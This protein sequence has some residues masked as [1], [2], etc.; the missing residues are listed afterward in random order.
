MSANIENATPALPVLPSREESSELIFS[1]S[2]KELQEMFSGWEAHGQEG[3]DHLGGMAN[4]F[5]IKEALASGDAH[6]SKLIAKDFKALGKR[7]DFLMN[8]EDT[9]A[10]GRKIHPFRAELIGLIAVHIKKWYPFFVTEAL[11]KYVV[12]LHAQGHST[13]NA[14][15][16]LISP[17]CKFPNVFRKIQSSESMLE[18]HMIRWLVPRLAYLKK[19][20]PDFPKKYDE[21]WESAR[22]EYLGEIRSYTLTDTVE[23]VKALS[24]LYTQLTD[25]FEQA[26][27]DAGKAKLATAAVKVMSGLYTLTQDPSLKPSLKLPNS[28][29][30]KEIFH[31]ELESENS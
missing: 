1:H 9:D 27:T 7:Y 21:I 12:R 2:R 18:N 6:G 25:A 14:I 19:G 13:T 20:S 17:A 29:E 10:F 4:C 30:E 23:Q 15:K 5:A 3:A 24:D 31:G 16:H 26:E 8:T 28:Q 11:R 22:K